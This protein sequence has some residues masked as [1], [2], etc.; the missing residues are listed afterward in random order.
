[1][2]LGHSLARVVILRICRVYLCRMFVEDV[3]RSQIPERHATNNFRNSP[4]GKFMKLYLQ[5]YGSNLESVE[6]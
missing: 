3:I 6:L 2:N 4:L 5:V 1:M